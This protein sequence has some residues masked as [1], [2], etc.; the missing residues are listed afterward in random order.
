MLK[1]IKF[2]LFIC[3]LLSTNVVKSAQQDVCIL[4]DMSTDADDFGALQLA[5]YYHHVNEINLR[6]VIYSTPN[7]R[8]YLPIAHKIDWWGY[9]DEILIGKNNSDN[10]PKAG[11]ERWVNHYISHFKLS[12]VNVRDGSTLLNEKLAKFPDMTVIE[13]GPAVVGYNA[14]AIHR[15]NNYVQMAGT[16]GGGY[17]FNAGEFLP[18]IREVAKRPQ[19]DWYSF[20]LG[21]H[22]LTGATKG[23]NSVFPH[24]TP[25]KIAYS[26][27]WSSE[28]GIPSYDLLAVA[29]AV[30]GDKYFKFKNGS[31]SFP[32]HKKGGIW[33]KSGTQRLAKFKD[34]KALRN[35]LNRILGLRPEDVDSKRASAD[36]D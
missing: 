35:E 24:V 21:R 9:Q 20:E 29:G 23:A 34:K 8:G 15:I 19:V 31:F 18:G 3:I 26:K 28:H 6:C 7:G 14:D 4:T 33:K 12:K 22:F 1:Y 11:D 32:D 27:F 5:L 25:L 10:G 36:S 30:H 13:I 16:L 2:G 17:E